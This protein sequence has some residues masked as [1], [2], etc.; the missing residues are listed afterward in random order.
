MQEA[1]NTLV[2]YSAPD[3]NDEMDIVAVSLGAVVLEKRLSLSRSLPGHHHVLSKEPGEFNEYVKRMRNV[4][5]SL[6]VYDLVPRPGDLKVRKEAFRH[7]VANCDIPKGTMLN[8]GMLEGKR[9]ER[10]I[11]PEYMDFFIGRTTRR[12]LKEDE[13]LSWNDV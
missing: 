1:F 3:F 13:A 8:E 4:K 12:T 7:I 9:P 2:G 11:S 10:G 6:G 5:A